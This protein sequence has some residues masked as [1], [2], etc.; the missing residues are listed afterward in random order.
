M[1]LLAACSPAQVAVQP[2]AEPEPWQ[3]TEAFV[4]RN[5]LWALPSCASGQKNCVTARAVSPCEHEEDNCD[6]AR[7]AQVLWPS[8]FIGV[9]VLKAKINIDNKVH[10]T[11]LKIYRVESPCNDHWQVALT[12]WTQD[13]SPTLL[14]EEGEIELIQPTGSE[15]LWEKFVVDRA[16]GKVV[17]RYLVPTDF[18]GDVG[19]HFKP[20]GSVYL[21]GIGSPCMTAI[22]YS[23]GRLENAPNDFCFDP[24]R[25]GQ[26][27]NR[28]KDTGLERPTD[29][30]IA[31]A[32]KAFE[33][34]S[35]IEPTWFDQRVFRISGRN[36]LLIDLVQTCT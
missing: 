21:S 23:G 14:S 29:K 4:I 8:P 26:N 6:T 11:G 16:T 12:G 15:F 13:L 1:A 30:D 10:E 7:A 32:R 27:R 28:H 18:P 33:G 3:P 31:I 17:E 20:D 22:K 24:D 34:D 35:R 2:A 5:E 9:E 19:F 36:E 25:K